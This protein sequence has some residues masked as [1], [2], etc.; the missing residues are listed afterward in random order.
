MRK[1][2]FISGLGA[3]EAA[4]AKLQLP[5]IETVHLNWLPPEPNESMLAYAK[6]IS[7]RIR[8]DN[9]IIAGLSFGGMIGIEIAKMRKVK[10]L[11]LISSAKTAAEIPFYFRLCRFIPLHKLLPLEMLAKSKLV[12]KIIIGA[13]TERQRK[14]LQAL[15]E[16]NANGFNKWAIHA[17]IHWKNKVIP[18]HVVH[19][20]GTADALLP[21]RF[22]KAD[23][24]IQK[25]THLMV[26]TKPKEISAILL[27][28]IQSL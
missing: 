21:Y 12:T 23:Y 8:E 11:L 6:R 17:V 22:V 3:N 9:P 7:D 26:L 13:K 25:G 1:V 28:E 2:Y 27:K 20:H 18:D 5:G 19:L 24:T 4:F 14:A 16:T 10:K 15:M